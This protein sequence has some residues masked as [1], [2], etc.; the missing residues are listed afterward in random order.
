MKNF[1]YLI[2]ILLIAAMF[3]SSCSIDKRLYRKGYN[4]QWNSKHPAAGEATASSGD[5]KPIEN[6]LVPIEAIDE[7][8]TFTA[9]LDDA[10]MII[11]N[12]SVIEVPETRQPE[13]NTES[14]Q[15]ERA[16]I[17]AKADDAPVNKILNLK[18]SG[19]KKANAAVVD[20]TGELKPHVLSILSLI[21]GILSFVAY[22]GAI[23]LGILAVVFGFIALKRINANPE[24]Y[25]GRGI[26]IA[27]IICG[28]VA[29]A[30]I[31][32][33]LIVMVL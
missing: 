7:A 29:L 27:G 28:F 32:T 19:S 21:A 16:D 2:S 15:A 12:N 20:Q 31:A 30:I 8:S 26:A 23:P 24:T 25:R 9:T 3:L 10:T 33:V 11:L 18:A 5:I 14:A 4:V 22:F 17:S 1:T 13:V 6:V